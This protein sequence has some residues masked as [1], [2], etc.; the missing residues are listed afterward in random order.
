MKVS[1][2]ALTYSNLRKLCQKSSVPSRLL[3]GPYVNWKNSKHYLFEN[4]YLPYKIFEESVKLCETRRS[5]R[6]TPEVDDW[7][8]K[9]SELQTLL[10][11]DRE[12]I[13][14]SAI[15][16]RGVPL[17]SI[18][19]WVQKAGVELPQG[20]QPQLLTGGLFQMTPAR[21][22]P[23]MGTPSEAGIAEEGD[24][25]A[26]SQEVVV[27]GCAASV[28]GSFPNIEA[29]SRSKAGSVVSMSPG[30]RRRLSTK[31]SPLKLMDVDQTLE[32]LRSNMSETSKGDVTSSTKII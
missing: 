21:S 32:E 27:Q 23:D 25:P 2:L 22:A 24:E 13:T 20:S 15:I 9:G 12:G 10:R 31:Q 19:E 30:V 29:A 11:K 14:H 17:P 18:S 16:D 28:K 1:S 8:E 3:T 26:S 7:K 4:P 6:Q 5:I